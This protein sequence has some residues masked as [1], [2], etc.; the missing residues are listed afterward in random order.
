M[1]PKYSA[2]IDAIQHPFSLQFI[3]PKLTAHAETN[4]CSKQH[5]TMQT[6]CGMKLALACCSWGQERSIEDTLAIFEK[7]IIKAASQKF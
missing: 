1:D 7:S 5:L 6:S 3:R 4:L 2:S